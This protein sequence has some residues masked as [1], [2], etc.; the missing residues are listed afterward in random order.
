MVCQKYLGEWDYSY[1]CSSCNFEETV[2]INE[3]PNLKLVWRVDWPMRWAFEDV[4]F[5]PGGK[6][7]SS[8][9]GSFDTGQQIIHKI[10]G[11][12]APIYLQYDFVKI[13]GGSG[14]MSSSSGEL[15]TLSQVDEI[16]EPQVVRWIFCIQR[17]NHDFAIS[18]DEDVIKIY[19]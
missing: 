11:K 18:F 19:E 17:P 9:G 15:F 6:D 4:D 10:W 16:Y 1:K 8:R 3:T 14:K 2:K 5:E 12:Q 7:H 13:K